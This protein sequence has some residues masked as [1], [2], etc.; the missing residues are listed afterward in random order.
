MH[1]MI[2]AAGRGQR[3]RPLTDTCPKPLLAVGGKPLIQWQIERLAAGGWRDIVINTGWLGAHIP[4]ALG[5][6]SALGVRL[7]YSPEPADAY[8]TGG[9]IATAL[10]LF[11]N[12]PF[13]V[14]SGDIY[15]TFDYARLQPVARR[16]AADPQHTAAHLVLTPNPEHNRD[17][18]MALDAQGRIRRDG[19]R[20]NYGNIGVFHPALFAGQP[21]AQA[22]K[23]FPWLYAAADAG[24][25]SGEL[26]SGAWHNIGTPEQLAAL[27]AA[28][29]HAAQDPAPGAPR[30]AD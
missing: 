9:G 11:G 14:V 29:T 7:R 18:D 13:V 28:L 5:D 4:A 26:F 10:P 8:E 1:A 12:D 16:I 30:R 3:M 25:V 6:G 23:L 17:G 24:R 21:Q 20:L 22:W 27:D 15:T 2:L 19:A